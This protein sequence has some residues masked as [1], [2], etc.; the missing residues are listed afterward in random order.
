MRSFLG[1]SACILTVTALLVLGYFLFVPVNGSNSR[2][3]S[4]LPDFLM[5]G[6]NKQV[7][8]LDFWSP[9]IEKIQGSEKAIPDFT[10]KSVL[11]YD[12]ST[13]KTL[14]EK[15]SKEQLPMASLTKIMTAIIALENKRE[16]DTYVVH[17]EDLVGEDSMGLSAGEEL[18]LYELL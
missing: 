15:D 13:N 16:D 6:I 8:V 3:T 5:L 11:L 12:L 7:T 4:P 18:G 17:A 14:F 10:A 1:Y 2:Y 9:F